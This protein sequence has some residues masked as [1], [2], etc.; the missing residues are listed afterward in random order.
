MRVKTSTSKSIFNRKLSY[1]YFIGKK[2]EAGL[3]LKGTEVKS[4][5]GGNGSIED[6]FV[7]LD[8]RGRPVLM[9][10]HIGEYPFGN[11]ANHDPYRVRFLL[12]HHHEINEIR[13]ALE[14]KGESVLAL[15][16]FFQ[17]GLCKVELA[18]CKGKKLF[19]KRRQL[20][21]KTEKIETERALRRQYL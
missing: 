13:G 5:R 7:R 11:V 1:N 18:I 9:N 15:K 6:A 3:V 10:A 8:R 2:F 20:K 12:L 17:R 21:E 4:L 16:V 14:R 19:D